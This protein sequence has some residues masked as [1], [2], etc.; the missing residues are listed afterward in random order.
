MLYKLIYASL[1]G[2]ITTQ[3]LQRV[4]KEWLKPIA[5]ACRQAVRGKFCLLSVTTHGRCYKY[6]KYLYSLA[7]FCSVCQSSWQ[8]LAYEQF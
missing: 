7:Y 3:V 1:L 2:L 4:T 8:N 5:I 6:K